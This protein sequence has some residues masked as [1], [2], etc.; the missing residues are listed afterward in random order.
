MKLISYF[1]L[2]LCFSSIFITGCT[3][4]DINKIT[5]G[6]ND[7]KDKGTDII[8]NLTTNSETKKAK[9][10]LAE[11]IAESINKLSISQISS[12]K[13]QSYEDYKKTVDKINLVIKT[14]NKHYDKKFNPLSTERKAYEQLTKN[15][16]KYSPLI[17]NFNELVTASKNFDKK[18]EKSADEVISAT[19]GFG[20]EL[21]LIQD[22]TLHKLV[23]NNV[24][25]FSASVGLLKL[26]KVCGPC[27]GIAMESLYWSSKNYIVDKGGELYN[28]F[29][30]LKNN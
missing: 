8:H 3:K 19:A 24:G 17:N 28:Y 5:E 7:Y 18:D 4:D 13:I 16:D 11:S 22:G 14:T 26:S 20:V 6:I 25:E 2:S 1:I 9:F 21:F 30:T 10:E 12:N 23:F 27:V 29:S 15:I